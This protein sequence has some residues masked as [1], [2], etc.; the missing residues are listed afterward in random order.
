MKGGETA[1]SGA[2]AEQQGDRQGEQ[3]VHDDSDRPLPRRQFHA[4][5]V[6]VRRQ[7]HTWREAIRRRPLWN[8]VYRTTV[9]LVGGAIM[10]GGLAFVPLPGPGW[11]IVFVGLAILATEFTWAH[12]LEVFARRRSEDWMDWLGRK[13]L[14]V[15]ALVGL[16]AM[17]FVAGLL[18]L[19]ARVYGVPGFI[20][21]GWYGGV[22]GLGG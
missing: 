16:G 20:P 14:L 5:R 22:P 7:L 2:A 17:V 3:Q 10:I 4:A 15:R 1:E 12:R 18:Y 6:A 21:E 13:S 19:L 8:H 11:L 9:G